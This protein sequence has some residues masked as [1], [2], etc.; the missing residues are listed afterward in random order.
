[1]IA[2]Y[3]FFREILEIKQHS[4]LYISI[5]SSSYFLA[6]MWDF[7]SACFLDISLS[8]KIFSLI[9]FGKYL[10]CSSRTYLPM[11]SNSVYIFGFFTDSWISICS[12][13][14]PKYLSSPCSV[15][16]DGMIYLVADNTKKVYSYDPEANMWQKVGSDSNSDYIHNP[17][18][19]KLIR[20]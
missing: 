10:V 2:C 8:F 14:I 15:C 17:V 4:T 20:C 5:C 12:P 9:V 1:M 13:F 19:Q 18:I 11:S 7:S 6:L 3:G 16:V